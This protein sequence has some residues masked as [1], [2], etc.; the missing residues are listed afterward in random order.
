MSSP[1]SAAEPVPASQ[2]GA[3]RL[4]A[5]T[6][7][8]FFAASAAPTPLYRLYQEAFAI[9]PLTI[10]VIFAVYAFSLLA[11][12]LI[13]GALSDHLGRR[14]A[15]AAAIVLQSLALVIFLFAD[16]AG[17]LIAARFLQGFATGAATSALGAALV[18]TDPK[19]GP[20]ATAVSPLFGMALGSLVTGALVAYGPF[21]LHLVYGLLLVIGIVELV[22][23][24]GVRETAILRPGLLASLRPKIVIPPQALRAMAVLTPL[25][26]SLWILGG[27]FLSLMPS[28]LVRVT[29]ISSPLFG[30]AV[31]AA[32]MLSGAVANLVLRQLP[33][34]RVLVIGAP[35]LIA[36]MALLLVGIHLGA[37]AWLAVGTI[38]AGVGF[39]AS[40]LG[41]IGT[42]M[43]LAEPHQ[44]AEL[45][46]ALYVESYLSFSLPAIVAG[47]LA[48]AIG[49]AAT[50]DIYTAAIALFAGGGLAATFLI[51]LKPRPA[52]ARCGPGCAEGK[53][54]A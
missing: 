18:D 40:F 43:P 10:T 36:G 17:M 52:G 35:T 41:V 39:G 3:F 4:Y 31:V 20:L 30:G 53:T 22:S 13:V 49:L 25:N 28:L 19:R 34:R 26:M 9:S 46:A 42:I 14:P 23:L 16:G 27:F 38:V 47:Y 6:L 15:V 29:G 32:V 44:R 54:A 2:P 45:L 11:A 33:M 51:G 37:V 8:T 1:V 5:L 7:M 12:L 21:P 24:A 48:G 50:A